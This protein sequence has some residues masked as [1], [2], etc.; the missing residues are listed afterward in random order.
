MYLLLVFD[1]SSIWQGA[2]VLEVE[3]I[4]IPKVNTLKPYSFDE[5]IK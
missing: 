5:Y 2:V 4:E 1:E 3:L